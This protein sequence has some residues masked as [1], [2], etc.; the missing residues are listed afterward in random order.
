MVEAEATENMAPRSSES[1]RRMNGPMG[2]VDFDPSQLDPGIR[3]TVMW[4]RSC[5]FKTTDSGDGKAKI[6]EGFGGDGWVCDFPHVA[7]VVEPAEQLVTEANRLSRLL[8][9]R[10]GVQ[11]QPLSL[12]S[13]NDP[14]I[15]ASYDVPSGQAMLVLTNVDDELLGLDWSGA[16]AGGAVS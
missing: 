11:V 6:A 8:T 10:F 5:G 7:M 12:E 4:L 2:E 9:I 13:S 1:A 16:H 3:G 14:H 15:D